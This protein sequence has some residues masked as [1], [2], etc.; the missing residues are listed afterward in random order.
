MT[1][2]P[3]AAYKRAEIDAR[4]WI[5]V[6]T[7]FSAVQDGIISRSAMTQ[8]SMM[9]KLTATLS[10]LGVWLATAATA[11]MTPGGIAMQPANSALAEEVHFFHNWILL[12]IITVISLFVL[13][14]LI[15]VIV[16][17]NAKSNPE[18]RKF[19]HNT[20]VEII[21]TGVPIIILLIIALPSFELLYKEDVTPDGKQVV[22]A[23]DGQTVD[24]V[25][26]NDFAES[27]MVKR[28]S[29]LQVALDNGSGQQVLR[30]R[31]D[32]RVDGFGDA[33]VVVSFETP[34]A[35]GER[36]IIR[37]GRSSQNVSGCPNAKRFIDACDKEIVMAPTMTIKAVGRQWGW[38]YSYP[39]FGDFEFLSD[40]AT[41]EEST[42]ETYLLE[43]NNRVVV[44]VGET[45]RI[46]TTASDVIHAWALPAF[47]VK[48][49]AVPG[50]INETWFSADREGIY[51]GQCS[52]IC[53]V[54]H[55]YMPIAVEVVSR[56]AFEAWVDS[57]RALAE[58]E[59]MFDSENIKLARSENAGASAE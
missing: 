54:R 30:Y 15:W 52:E 29:H 57:Q 55:S 53:G 48:V 27:R 36:V 16:R 43:V 24:F 7:I 34:P 45:I 35:P 32:Y 28:R 37:G 5:G 56:P 9:K 46:T 38:N 39:D 47:A 33:E 42:P 19:S 17:Y 8:E 1:L 22:V 44:P 20:L 2:G 13:A 26:P 58:M 23:G 49:D 4:G 21:W 11:Q 50:R 6:S 3:A 25:F 41:E 10:G 51:Y 40:M 31:D 12:P 14:L 59:P 18:P